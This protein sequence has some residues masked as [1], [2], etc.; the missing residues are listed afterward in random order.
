[1]LTYL[2]NL[3]AFAAFLLAAYVAYRQ[4]SREDG[5]TT[6]Q[7]LRKLDGV[8]INTELRQQGFQSEI[9]GVAD[10][11]SRER[12]ALAENF[13]QQMATNEANFKRDLDSLKEQIKEL[14]V[15]RDLLTR[16]DERFLSTAKEFDKLDRK[17]DQILSV[18]T[19]K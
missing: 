15:M 2:P 11:A 6:A 10:H 19:H 16:V 14:P 9:E 13:R 8:A 1:M 4:E 18:L 5:Q 3:L 17:M 12:L 7:R